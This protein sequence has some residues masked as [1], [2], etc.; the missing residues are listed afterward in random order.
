MAKRI[1]TITL[2][3]VSLIFL[4][5]CSKKTELEEGLAGV[6]FSNPDFTSPKLFDV[7]DKLDKKWGKENGFSTEWSIEWNGYLIAPLSGK[8][9]IYLETNKY[10][11]VVLNNKDTIECKNGLTKEFSVPMIDL[12]K[13]PIKI[14]YAHF[15]GGEG[16][17]KLSWS[18]KESE[19]QVISIPYLVYSRENEANWEWV[20]EP[21]IENVDKTQFQFVRG[22][23]K[24]IAYDSLYFYG[25]PANH[26]VWNWGNEILVGL[27]RGN[28]LFDILHHSIDRSKQVA[29]LARSTDGG[30]TWKLEDPINFVTDPGKPVPLK[31]SINLSNPDLAIRH[32][33]ER[34]YYSYD[35]GKTWQGPFLFT[36]LD[37][38]ELTSRTD[39]YVIDR[40]TYLAF[41]SRIDNKV[42]ANLPDRAFCAKTTNGGKTFQFVSWMTETDTVRS[43]MSSTIRLNDNHLVSA[44]R[45]RYD[46]HQSG[47]QLP[48]QNWIDVYESFDNGNTWQF[49]SKVAETDNGTRN[50]N[51]PS[52]VLLKDGRLCVTYGSRKVPYGIR[53]KISS[54]NGKTWGKEIIIR[55]DALTKDVGYPRSVVRT[56]GK[57]V[58]IY[59]YTTKE[60]VEQHIAATIWNP[61]DLK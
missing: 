23:N 48:Q 20:K 11:K 8:V 13:Y 36:G 3:V 49:L 24:I 53:A 46:P 57:V 15:G 61:A 9:K 6:Y 17:L 38:G 34:F 19:P 5:S 50:G 25:W 59:Y 42:K 30:E 1:S 35:R 33:R 39:Y 45:R 47:K 55:D 51:P 32:E 14:Y 27:M 16:F 37:I 54:D 44:L 18:W 7:I 12:E 28:Y 22:E 29:L 4:A 41:L 40:N 56:D 2:F 43:V 26:G 31:T 21:A 10:A 52:L 60:K 58:T